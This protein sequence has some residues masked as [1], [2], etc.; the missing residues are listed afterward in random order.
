MNGWISTSNLNRYWKSRYSKISELQNYLNYGEDSSTKTNKTLYMEKLKKRFHHIDDALLKGLMEIRQILKE[1]SS[2]NIFKVDI[3]EAIQITR[4]QEMHKLNLKELDKTME[5][6]RALVKKEIQ[7]ACNTSYMN[8]KELKKITLEDNVINTGKKAKKV[9][10][11]FDF[12]QN[13]K[14]SN[15]IKDNEDKNFAQNFLKDAMPYAQDATRRT[16][17]KKLLRYIR[18]V[19]FLFNE[20]K[21]KMISFSLSSLSTKFSKLFNSIGRWQEIPMLI[22]NIHPIRDEILFNPHIEQIQKS[23]FEEF[24]QEKIYTVIY[25]KSFV[26]PQEFPNYMVCFE[27]VFEVSV[28][29]N[30]N[31]N[32]RIKEDTQIGDLFQTIRST[33]DGCF[34]AL[35]DYSRSKL[36]ILLN[37]NNYSNINFKA[38]QE[39]CKPEMM[40]DYIE[41]FE[42]ESKDISLLTEKVHMGIFE[43]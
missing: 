16:H 12:G 23:I 27:E 24:I 41:R 29:Q 3:K 40:K 8:Y 39:D 20:A 17:Y 35:E 7:K 34:K 14:S 28:D 30:S 25:R 33:V 31:L 42:N 36:S 43:F 38:L 2:I 15:N 18:V 21:Y 5:Y 11:N 22:A 6:Y 37:Y 19:D 32:I 9:D 13:K 10:E 1:M 26:D 4:F